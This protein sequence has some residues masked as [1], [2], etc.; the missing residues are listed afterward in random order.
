I[1]RPEFQ[2]NI[3]DRS[4]IFYPDMVNHRFPKLR[5]AFC[6]TVSEAQEKRNMTRPDDG[7]P[8]GTGSTEEFFHTAG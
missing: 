3:P 4:E 5:K 8:P 7:S 6:A 2:L 1:Q